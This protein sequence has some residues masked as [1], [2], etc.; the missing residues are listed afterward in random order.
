[1][2]SRAGVSIVFNGLP[3]LTGELRQRA[4]KIVRATALDVANDAKQ[5]APVDTGTLRRSITTEFAGP[6][7]ARVGPSVD[8][9]IHVEY[10]TRRMAARPYLTP[11]AEAARPR[12]VEAMTKLLD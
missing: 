12:F 4:A 3:A 1:V 2:A 7:S 9:G 11:A 8:Y 5:R 6:L 10:G